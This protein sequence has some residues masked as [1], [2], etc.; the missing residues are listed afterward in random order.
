M[1]YQYFE[2]PLETVNNFNPVSCTYIKIK[3]KYQ[4]TPVPQPV[5][6][7][8]E[9]VPELCVP[10]LSSR[11]MVPGF[12]VNYCENNKPVHLNLN[13]KSECYSGPGCHEDTKINKCVDPLL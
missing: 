11:M 2:N 3:N 1:N 7:N 5:N 8:G 13:E 6:L 12:G 4:N 10:N 9:P